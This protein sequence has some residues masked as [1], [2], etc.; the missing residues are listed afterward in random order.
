MADTVARIEPFL[1]MAR[2]AKGGAAANLIK[3][4]TSAVCQRFTGD[5]GSEP[6]V[7]ETR[8]TYRRMCRSPTAFCLWI[9]RIARYAQ[10]QRGRLTISAWTMEL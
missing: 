3:D 5:L 8:L 10:Y 2:G 9:R 4:A 1:L 6:T 7:S